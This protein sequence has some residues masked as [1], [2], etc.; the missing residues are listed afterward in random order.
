[1]ILLF[2]RGSFFFFFPYVFLG[3]VAYEVPRL[4]VESELQLLADT[5]DPAT[6]D[7]SLVC[8]LHC[9]LQQCQIPDPL[10]EARDCT[11]I[12]TETSQI[13]FRCTTIGTPSLEFF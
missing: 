7:L 11:R 1:M 4:G 9:S 8:D 5:T 6:W 2:L 12:L 13:H 3:P 10:R